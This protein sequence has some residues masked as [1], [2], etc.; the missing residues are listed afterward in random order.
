MI[1]VATFTLACSVVHSVVFRELGAMVGF[2]SPHHAEG[3]SILWDLEVQYSL[4]NLPEEPVVPVQ[5]FKTT[6]SEYCVVACFPL[7]W[8]RRRV[9]PFRMDLV[10][11]V[12]L[13]L[14]VHRELHL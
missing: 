5:V 13:V 1:E 7:R 4:V 12:L 6:C 14:A 10:F 2:V 3:A 11:Q 8:M 9:P